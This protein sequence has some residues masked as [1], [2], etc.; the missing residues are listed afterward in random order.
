M[1][2]R[3]DVRIGLPSKGRLQAD[4]LQFLKECG[5]PIYKS[6]ERQY[7]ASVPSVPGLRVIFQNVGDIVNGVRDGG[8]DFGVVGQDIIAERQGESG[9]VLEL[10]PNLGFGACSLEIAVPLAWQVSNLAELDQWLRTFPQLP[11]GNWLRRFHS[12][13]GFFWANII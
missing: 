12:R 10:Y 7:I 4:T 3:T 11:R 2:K 13:F 8:L 1:Q 9:V 5:L 6:N